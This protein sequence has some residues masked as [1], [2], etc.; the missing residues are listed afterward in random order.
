MK[1]G[2][3]RCMQTEDYCPG[4][5]DFKFIR[6]KKG[7][8]EGVEGDIEIIGFINCGGF[9]CTCCVSGLYTLRCMCSMHAHAHALWLIGRQ[10]RSCVVSSMDARQNI[11]V[12]RAHAGGQ[13]VATALDDGSAVGTFEQGGQFSMVPLHWP[14]MTGFPEAVLHEKE[15]RFTP[16]PGEARTTRSPQT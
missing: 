1:V 5:T 3:I 16:A 11:P 6:E 13:P 10:E 9:A 12:L 2:I 15:E 7:A 14:D 8:F 4:T